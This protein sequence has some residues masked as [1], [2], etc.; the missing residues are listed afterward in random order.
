M[1]IVNCYPIPKKYFCCLII[2]TFYS[3]SKMI[4]VIVRRKPF[5]SRRSRILLLF[6][7]IILD[8]CVSSMLWLHTMIFQLSLG[9]VYIA[10]FLSG[11][12][13]REN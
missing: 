8:A 13:D 9:A 4:M 2:S 12:W 1:K 11:S 3:R 7:F 6:P 5:I 10:L